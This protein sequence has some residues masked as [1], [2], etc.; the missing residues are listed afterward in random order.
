MCSPPSGPVRVQARARKAPDVTLNGG[1]NPRDQPEPGADSMDGQ[2]Q[3]VAAVAAQVTGDKTPSL[4]VVCDD[5][6][7]FRALRGGKWVA[8]HPVPGT[9]ADSSNGVTD[10]TRTDT[11]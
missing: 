9:Q 6:S 8:F 11:L 7:V 3:V 5:G 2:R 10:G 1:T 4:V